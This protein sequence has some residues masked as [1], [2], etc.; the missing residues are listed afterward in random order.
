MLVPIKPNQ[1]LID[2]NSTP[3]SLKNCKT[4]INGEE[5]IKVISAINEKIDVINSYHRDNCHAH[6]NHYKIL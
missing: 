2:G 5:K 1:I 6:L 4:F 3:K